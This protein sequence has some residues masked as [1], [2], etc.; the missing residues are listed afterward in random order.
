MKMI[1]NN[2]PLKQYFG[3]FLA[4]LVAAVGVTILLCAYQANGKS[5]S[6]MKE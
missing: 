1:D 2:M 6:R 4:G 3:G 5:S